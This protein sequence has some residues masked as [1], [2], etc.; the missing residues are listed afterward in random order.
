MDSQIKYGYGYGGQRIIFNK[1]EV[2]NIK[3][4]DK[5]GIDFLTESGFPAVV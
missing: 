2:Q 3:T 5:Q 4:F 1:E